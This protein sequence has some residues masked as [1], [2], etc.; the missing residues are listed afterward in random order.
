MAGGVSSFILNTNGYLALAGTAPSAANQFLTY[1]QQEANVNTWSL[2]FPGGPLAGPDNYLVLPF[3]TDLTAA[4]SG[5][6]E[7]RYQTTG[8]APNRVCT[9]QWKNVKDKPRA[10]NSFTPALVGTQFESFSFQAKLYENGQVEFVY[11]PSTAG[12]GPDD[13]RTVL[14]A[15]KGTS[16]TDAVGKNK[17]SAQTWDLGT[18][19]DGAYLNNYAPHNVRGT[20][21]PD[22]GCT[23]RFVPTPANDLTVQLVQA[24]TQLPVPQGAP[25]PVRALVA[26]VGAATQSNV[27]VTLTV[28]GANTNT[29]TQTIA[30][31]PVGG[32]PVAVTFASYAPTTPGST[33]LTVSVPADD[34]NANNSASLVQ[35]VNTSTYSYADAGVGSLPGVGYGPTDVPNAGVVRLQT[36]T[37]LR[38]TQVRVFLTTSSLAA[39]TTAGK[40]VFGVLLNAAG[41]VLARSPDHVVTNSELNTYV[42]FPLTNPPTLPAGSNFY[43]GAAQTYQPGQTTAYSPLGVQANG[44]GQPGL[45]YGASTN[46]A[47]API[48][49]V[50]Q[51]LLTS[52]LMIEAVTQTVLG[53]RDAALAAAVGLYPNPAHGAFALTVPAG[54]LGAAT[55]TL[56]NT[57]GQAVLTRRLGLPAAGGTAEFDVRG[58]A[59]GVYTLQ[60]LTGETLV[61]KRVVVE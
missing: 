13:Y 19:V 56:H 44:P 32:A 38:V 6:A 47:I 50:A 54:P 57:L 55:A 33:T 16:Q 15:L 37:P 46:Q 31:L 12:A 9:V 52:K 42:T 7:Y 2:N 60:L 20:V 11:G 40:T 49:L 36:S 14:V 30:T 18:F 45:Y 17:G 25:H 22:V 8:T 23:Y 4:S 35:Q 3:A 34:S 5:P 43:V 48:D 41:A 61:V 24:L 21:R 28:T 1:A 59:P 27:T 39:A 53:T 29:Y 26:N 10:A 58:L 51:G